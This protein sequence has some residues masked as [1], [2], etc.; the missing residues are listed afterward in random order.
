M[1]PVKGTYCLEPRRLRSCS[2]TQSASALRDLLLADLECS[3]RSMAYRFTL[4]PPRARVSVLVAS[5]RLDLPTQI[6]ILPTDFCHPT[7]LSTCTRA[8]GSRPISRPRGMSPGRDGS[9]DTTFH[10]VVARFRRTARSGPRVFTEVASCDRASD[11]PVARSWGRA[12]LADGSRLRSLEP[13]PPLSFF[14]EEKNKWTIRCAF[15][16]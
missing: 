1:N 3:V 4:S 10:D 13:R 8:R 16:R 14:R 11:T 2:D 6:A 12:A 9:R 7:N 15:L 5:F